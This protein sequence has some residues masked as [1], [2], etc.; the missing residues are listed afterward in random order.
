[1]KITL[2]TG[3]LGFIGSTLANKL[4]SKKIVD[5]CVLLDNFGSF[6]NPLK[7]GSVYLVCALDIQVMVNL[8]NIDFTEESL[9][10]VHVLNFPW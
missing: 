2:I 1:M 3:G 10:V 4:V 6:I 8:R 5:K 7:S 9:R